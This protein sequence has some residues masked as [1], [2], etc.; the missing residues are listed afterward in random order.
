MSKNILHE[1]QSDN[2]K[3]VFFANFLLGLGFCLGLVYGVIDLCLGMVDINKYVV[4][5]VFSLGL[6]F[7]QVGVDLGL[8]FVL[9]IGF[10]AIQSVVRCVRSSSGQRVAGPHWSCCCWC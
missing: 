7:G 8:I 10:D 3:S 5:T 9:N 4:Y 6:G 1:C 2:S